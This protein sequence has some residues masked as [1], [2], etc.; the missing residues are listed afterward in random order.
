[1]LNERTRK[2]EERLEKEVQKTEKDDMERQKIID[3]VRVNVTKNR[4]ER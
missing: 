1:V 2:L 3:R 4:K